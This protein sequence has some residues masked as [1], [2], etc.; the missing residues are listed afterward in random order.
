MSSKYVL[1]RINDGRQWTAEQVKFLE[2]EE[3]NMGGFHENPEVG[4]SCILNPQFGM[5]FTWVTTKIVKFEYR[6][7]ELHFNTQNNSYILIKLED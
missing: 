6:D 7:I 4:R 3:E 5:S 2:W 1:K